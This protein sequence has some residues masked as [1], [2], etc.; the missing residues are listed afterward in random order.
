MD[1]GTNDPR[2]PLGQGEDANREP[3]SMVV[4]VVAGEVYDVSTGGRLRATGNTVLRGWSDLDGPAV[5]VE[6]MW[7]QEVTI[8]A[9]VWAALDGASG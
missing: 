2:Q 9:G 8:P 7:G 3:V 4:Q 6:S 1:P 5:V